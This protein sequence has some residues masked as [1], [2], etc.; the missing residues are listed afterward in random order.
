MKILSN[1]MT[2]VVSF[3]HFAS[4]HLTMRTYQTE[5]NPAKLCNK[6]FQKTTLQE[7]EQVSILPYFQEL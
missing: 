3:S 4:A 5:K 7:Q 6:S 2:Y 1:I